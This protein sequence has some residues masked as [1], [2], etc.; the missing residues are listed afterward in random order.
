MATTTNKYQIIQKTG[1]QDTVILHPETDAKVV[2]Y[3]N[4]TSGLNAETVQDAL[5]EMK[6][7]ID[8]ITGGG[9]VTG[10]KGEAEA[11]YRTGKVNIT[12]ANI[13]LG[14]ADNT[15][16]MNKPVSTAQQAAIDAVKEDA[17][18]KYIP[19]TQKGAASGVASLDS[20]GKVPSS[21]LP[22]YVDD[23]LEYDSLSGFP[24]TGESGKIYV[25][26]DTNKTY[27]WSG[28][29]YVEISASLALGETSS[30][31]Y[32]G[33]KGKANADAIAALQNEQESYQTKTDNSLETTSKTVTGAIN[34]VKDTADSA[35]STAESANSKAQ[36][37]ASDIA[38]IKSGTTPAGAASKLSTARTITLSG[39]VTGSVSF[40]GSANKTMTATLK[41]SGVTPGTYSAIS[42][43]AK[44]IVTEGAQSVEVGTSGQSSPS[45]TLAVGGLFFKML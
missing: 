17:A 44:G 5:D 1:E 3:D 28:S 9:T 2:L 31:A 29:G 43:D 35:K 7:D 45:A 22:S 4:G 30:T 20:T 10:V 16:D 23:V 34:E 13:G 36:A 38:N 24:G 37:N 40:D 25:A 6:G 32:P 18:G 39:D 12:R 33:N 26:K 42:V 8:A 14:N 15:S 19:L 27:R 41:N 11:E 21:Q